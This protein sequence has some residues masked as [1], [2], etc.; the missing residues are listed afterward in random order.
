MR[1]SPI[2]VIGM[3]RSGTSLLTR[4]IEDAGFFLG[5]KKDE[6]DE[7][8]FFQRLN[9][10]MLSQLHAS[11]DTPYTARFLT[12]AYQENMIRVI[13]AHLRSNDRIQFLG[14]RM[15][16][17]YRNIKDI[18]FPWGWKDPRNTFTLPVWHTLFPDA[19]IIHIYR[20]PID[21]AESLRKREMATNF[22]SRTW[23]DWLKES[24]LKGNVGYISSLRVQDIK[25]GIKLW[26]EY[27]DAAL[28]I[29]ETYPDGCIRIK[30]EDFL[31]Q[32]TR[33]LERLSKFLNIQG[34]G[35]LQ[36]QI[37]STRKYA[38]LGNDELRQEYERM[39]NTP[40]MMKLGYDAIK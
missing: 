8:V 34:L 26:M 25:E 31:S 30:Y 32:P 33:E 9:I 23:G 28:R 24:M 21:V 19:K 40:L 17:K 29:E 12:P 36:V 5:Q 38:F 14:L 37:D 15:F 20:N 1:F 2:I 13:E 11:W 27:T 16:L 4:I 7:A 10:W 3:H 35:G 39:R 22:V 6:N 18:D